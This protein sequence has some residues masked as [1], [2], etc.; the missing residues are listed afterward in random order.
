VVSTP[1]MEVEEMIME[2]ERIKRIESFGEDSILTT[3]GER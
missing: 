2:S 1:S 3:E